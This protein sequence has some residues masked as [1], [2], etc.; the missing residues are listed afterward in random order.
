MKYR[1]I[2]NNKNSFTIQGEFYEDKGILWWKK[3]IKYWKTVNIFGMA[4]VYGY[5]TIDHPIAEFKTLDEAK[6]QVELW[7]TKRIIHNI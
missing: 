1:I 6:K 4:N 3:R 5:I 2:E 7:Q